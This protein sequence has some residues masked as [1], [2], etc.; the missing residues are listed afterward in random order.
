MVV[1]CKDR[2]QWK[3]VGGIFIEHWQVQSRHYTLGAE[4]LA[5]IAHRHVSV[6]QALEKIN[7]P[8]KIVPIPRM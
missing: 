1:A 7:L 2:K 3:A 4:A 5:Q 6:K 8:Q